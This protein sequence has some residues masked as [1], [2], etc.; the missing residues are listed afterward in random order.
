MELASLTNEERVYIAPGGNLSTRYFPEAVVYEK[1]EYTVNP[2][3]EKYKKD[4]S[5]PLANGATELPAIEISV[6]TQDVFRSAKMIVRT[7]SSK[8]CIPD[9]TEKCNTNFSQEVVVFR[10]HYVPIPREQLNFG[11]GNVVARTD[12]RTVT[13][14]ELTKD[15]IRIVIAKAKEIR[16]RTPAEGNC[17]V[18]NYDG[19]HSY[20]DEP[21]DAKLVTHLTGTNS[22]YLTYQ[23][24]DKLNNAFAEYEFARNG[25]YHNSPEKQQ[26]AI[27]RGESILTT[28][29]GPPATS[30]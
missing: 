18:L 12:D 9:D 27:Q 2:D 19:F 1:Y 30:L 24:V 7:T 13:M 23:E 22:E 11:S 3:Y 20:L 25:C 28:L 26:R 6:Y 5:R 17:E 8:E 29:F 10:D 14:L 16:A 21:L 4:N 15:T